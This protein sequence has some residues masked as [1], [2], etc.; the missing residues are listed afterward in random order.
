MQQTEFTTAVPD[1]SSINTSTADLKQK[2]VAQALE[3]TNKFYLGI[4]TKINGRA[5]P[6][7][8]GLIQSLLEYFN[9]HQKELTETRPNNRGKKISSIIKNSMSLDEL[10]VLNK[11]LTNLNGR[12]KKITDPQEEA[13]TTI[14]KIEEILNFFY[15]KTN[16]I[17]EEVEKQLRDVFKDDFHH[18]DPNRLLSQ[19][20]LSKR[21]RID[22]AHWRLPLSQLK[23][24]ANKL[25]QIKTQLIKNNPQILS[26]SNIPRKKNE[27]VKQSCHIAKHIGLSRVLSTKIGQKFILP[28]LL[29]AFPSLTQEDLLEEKSPLSLGDMLAREAGKIG[30]HPIE[31]QEKLLST[32]ISISLNSYLYHNLSREEERETQDKAKEINDIKNK[33]K[34]KEEE[35]KLFAVIKESE[36]KEKW[37]KAYR[38]IF[39]LYENQVAREA[40]FLDR[41]YA[42]DLTQHALMSDFPKAILAFDPNKHRKISFTS[43]LS[44]YLG[45]RFQREKLKIQQS[46]RMHYYEDL[47]KFDIPSSHQTEERVEAKD[48]WDYVFNG[49]LLKEKEKKVLETYISNDGNIAKTHAQLKQEKNWTNSYTQLV[50]ETRDITRRIRKNAEPTITPI[51]KIRA[52][53]Q[54]AIYRLRQPNNFA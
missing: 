28:Q 35:D 26:I 41:K 52:K 34:R 17:N 36:S 53:R 33:K 54:L 38:I 49:T 46:F 48:F 32:L 24:I 37:Q 31:K 42:D 22:D 6:I 47:S 50:E 51:E 16:S 30:A 5:F 21:Q 14:K 2:A 9:R 12:V 27:V 25:A 13:Q 3:Q 40:S 15:K 23:T 10:N 8:E 43:F 44:I 4:K 20:L 19:F 29:D 18:V 11:K 39:L 45:P 7:R 1:R